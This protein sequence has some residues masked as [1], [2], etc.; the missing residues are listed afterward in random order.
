MSN[1]N[2]LFAHHSNC[3]FIHSFIS[4]LNDSLIFGQFNFTD[5]IDRI[6]TIIVTQISE[7]LLFY[8]P[9]N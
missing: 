6:I 1:M 5:E 7:Y 8:F 2:I 3:L 4:Q 9:F